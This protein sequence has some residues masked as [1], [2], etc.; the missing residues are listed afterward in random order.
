[1]SPSKKGNVETLTKGAEP[2]AEDDSGP[3][4]PRETAPPISKVVVHPLVLLSAVDH[5]DRVLRDSRN[6]S[7]RVVGVLLGSLRS[8]ILD[9][10]NCFALPFEEDFRDSHVWFLD[11]DYLETMF[12]M[13]RKV[14]ARE[15]IVGWYHTGKSLSPNDMAINEVLRKY[16]PHAVL[17][18]IRTQEFS[19]S[20]QPVEAFYAVDEI[21]DDGTP[22]SKTFE[23]LPA[24]IDAEEA[25]E[26]GVEHLLRD[27]KDSTASTLTHQVVEQIDALSG[28]TDQLSAV[29]L[30]LKDVEETKLPVNHQILYRLQDML[31]LLPD[32]SVESLMHSLH[33]KSNDHTAIL[34]VSAIVRS[35]LALHDLINNKLH[36]RE[37]ERAEMEERRLK[38]SAATGDSNKAKPGNPP[39][40]AA[41]NGDAKD[42]V[43][44]KKQ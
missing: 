33:T 44:G 13:F 37:T 35:V 2:S 43:N 30:Y 28:L 7:A 6:D 1:M 19:P 39:S 20:G 24:E 21:H 26:V 17:V 4:A 10:S 31:N 11:H 9:I 38:L 22:T 3:S 40:P 15:R 12:A 14:N 41:K 34:Y 18:R 16:N 23:H 42:L 8:G 32:V 25:E 36:N 5:S 27:I 29:T